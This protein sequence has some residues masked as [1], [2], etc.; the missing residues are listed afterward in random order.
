MKL[1][2]A[3]NSIT[4][5]PRALCA[6]AAVLAAVGIVSSVVALAGHYDEEFLRTARAKAAVTAQQQAAPP[7]AS[8]SHANLSASHQ[9]GMAGSHG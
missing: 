6:A 9:H 8:T 3:P 5:V 1:N 2:R 7:D 4:T